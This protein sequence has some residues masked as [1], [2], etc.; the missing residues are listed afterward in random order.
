MAET[1]GSAA[2]RVLIDAR[3]LQGSDAQRGLGSYVRGLLSGL[4]EVGFDKR[5]ALLFDAR[6]SVPELPGG[7]W[8]AFSVRP[9][10]RGRPGLLEEAAWMGRWLAGLRPAIYHA[11]TLALPG[12]SPVPMVVTLHDLI[13]WALPSR[14]MLG[15]RTRWWV[16]RRLL[17]RADLVLAVS[18]ATAADGRRL[19]GIR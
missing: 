1:P 6:D 17:R 13:P 19:A 12:R 10:Y 3:P 2:G 18:E 11:T 9:R 5:A 16:G 7:R 4:L 15:E 14:A 8:L